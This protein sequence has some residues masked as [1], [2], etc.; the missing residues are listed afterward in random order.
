MDTLIQNFFG[1]MKMNNFRGDIT[2]TS[3][4]KEALGMALSK[5][6]G[7]Q[8]SCTVEYGYLFDRLILEIAE[9]ASYLMPSLCSTQ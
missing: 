8:L 2:D 1:I 9:A 3:A 5:I 4:K 7:T 6:W